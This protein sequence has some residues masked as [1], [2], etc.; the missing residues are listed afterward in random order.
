M[1]TWGVR[2]S[3]YVDALC[4]CERAYWLSQGM[5]EENPKARLY[6]TRSDCREEEFVLA[7][8]FRRDTSWSEGLV[9]TA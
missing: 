2:A 8:S 5:V 3:A 6:P 7:Y 9:P 1:S 4:M